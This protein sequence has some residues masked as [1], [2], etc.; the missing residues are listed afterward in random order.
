MGGFGFGLTS[1]DAGAALLLDAA[2]PEVVVEIPLGAR[3]A[4]VWVVDGRAVAEIEGFEVATAEAADIREVLLGATGLVVDFE[5]G[6]I[7]LFGPWPCFT[8]RDTASADFTSAGLNTAPSSSTAETFFSVCSLC[9]SRVGMV[10]FLKAGDSG[11]VAS[12]MGVG[13]AEVTAVA[14]TALSSIPGMLLLLSAS[15]DTVFLSSSTTF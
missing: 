10:T 3:V 15:V 6:L 11:S 9:F 14:G 7:F 8:W 5:L 12:I 1:V 13:I 4:P 2:V